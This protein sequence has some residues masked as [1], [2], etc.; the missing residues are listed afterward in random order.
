MVSKADEP[1]QS[2]AAATTATTAPVKKNPLAALAAGKGQVDLQKLIKASL[3]KEIQN[4][5]ATIKD[6][7]K[8]MEVV[9][10]DGE[11]PDLND[12]DDFD[13]DDSDEE[14]DETQA[15]TGDKVVENDKTNSDK[16]KSQ[17][18]EK[19]IVEE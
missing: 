7:T 13:D 14:D 4:R 6:P 17:E 8:A 11:E 12:E 10:G 5:V 18:T 1:K 19:K 3:E 9:G 16:D 15:G 2:D